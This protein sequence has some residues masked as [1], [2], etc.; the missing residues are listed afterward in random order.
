MRPARLAIASA[1]LMATMPLAQTAD[2]TARQKAGVEGTDPAAAYTALLPARLADTRPLHPTVDST[3]AGLGAIK[4]DTMMHLTV[5]GRGGVPVDAVAAVLNVVATEADAPGFLTLFPCGQPRPIASNVNYRPHVD[6]AN[7]VISKIGADGS[8]CIYSQQTTDVVVDVN[9]AF[10]PSTSFVPV[11][12][13]RLIDTRPGH[14]TVDGLLQGTGA[15]QGSSVNT[16]RVAGRA[17][18]PA[19]ASAIAMTVTVTDAEA[20]GYATVYPCGTEPATASNISYSAGVS[21][22][23]LVIA[24]IGSAGD[25]C[26]FTQSRANL[27]ADVTGYFGANAGFTA[28]QPA[29][30]MDLRPGYPTV[31]GPVGP[32]SFVVGRIITQVSGRG[33]VPVGARA[34]VLNI[35]AVEEQAPGYLTVFPCNGVEVLASNIN[36]ETNR[37]IA[38]LV[39]ATLDSNGIICY[40]ASQLTR[41]VVDV[42]G[43]FP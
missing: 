20:D 28:L 5:A 41:I 19:N 9:G 23:N 25:V 26:I 27:V 17:G 21:T 30:L 32:G 35:T 10:G 3:F 29:R 31:D 22:P 34:A 1:L 24:K 4:A 38:N 43:Y 7:A 2:A 39:V 18:V 8:I 42:L 37:P 11:D 6:V 15:A 16:V 33:G 14:S 36:Y 12:P 40:N 13:A